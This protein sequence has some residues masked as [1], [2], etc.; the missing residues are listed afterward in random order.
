MSHKKCLLCNILSSQPRW[1]SSDFNHLYICRRMQLCYFVYFM[2]CLTSNNSLCLIYT[3]DIIFNYW[4]LFFAKGEI[5]WQDFLIFCIGAEIKD[6]DFLVIFHR[7]FL[8]SCNRIL[9][10]SSCLKMND[11][12]KLNGF[13]LHRK[14]C[15]NKFVDQKIKNNFEQEN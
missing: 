6:F 9:Q 1:I 5:L 13:D 14:M 12:V 8:E 15:V 11:I 3:T 7:H 2:D 4:N 10:S